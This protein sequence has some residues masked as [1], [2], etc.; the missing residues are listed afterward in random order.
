MIPFAHF[1]KQ[2]CTI[3]NILVTLESQYSYR[4][5][6][7]QRPQNVCFQNRQDA[8]PWPLLYPRELSGFLLGFQHKEKFEEGRLVWGGRN[9]FLKSPSRKQSDF[10]SYFSCCLFNEQTQLG[11]CLWNSDE[12]RWEHQ[13]LGTNKFY[14][15]HTRHYL[16]ELRFPNT[17]HFGAVAV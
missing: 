14:Y 9:I 10:Y 11:G 12:T 13:Y 4:E 2:S 16:K 17:S 3:P 1:T 15:R 5:K 8:F 7:Y 6:S